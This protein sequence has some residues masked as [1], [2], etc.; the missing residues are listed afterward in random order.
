MASTPLPCEE[1]KA[2]EAPVLSLHHSHIPTVTADVSPV[3]LSPDSQ[4]GLCFYEE[5]S[6][7][8]TS[9]PKLPSRVPAPFVVLFP[10]LSHGH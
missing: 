7:V 1:H 2:A 3:D 6:A 9:T 5:G 8:L 4:P 10:E